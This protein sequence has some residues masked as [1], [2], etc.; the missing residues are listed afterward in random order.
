MSRK[1]EIIENVSTKQDRIATI[2][3]K[4]SDQPILSIAQHIDLEWLYVAF[5]QTRKD[6]VL[7][8]DEQSAEEY[9]SNLRENLESLLDK[10]KSGRYR[11]PAVKRIYIDKGKGG[12]TRP[13]GVPTFEDKVLQRA[14]LMATSPILE[15]KFYDFSYG[16]RKG[17]SAH[18]ALKALRE[19]CMKLGGGWVIDM[20]IRKYFD[21]IDHNLLMDI[22]KQRVC[23]GV[24][25]RVIGKWLKAGVMEAGIISYSDEGTPQG[26][27]ISP[28]LSNIFLHEVLD[29][30]FIKVVQ[31]RLTG[32]SAIIRFADDAVLIFENRIDALRVLKVLPKRFGKYKLTLH[33]EK[34]RLVKFTNPSVNKYD[35]GKPETFSFLGFTLYWGKSRKGDFLL[36]KLKTEKNR[37]A[38]SI[39]KVHDWLK[40]H[41]H[42]KICEHHEKL[43]RMMKGH[44]AY[45][46]MSFNSRAMSRYFHE[47]GRNW[48]KWLK[49]RSQKKRLTWEKFVQI[50]EQYSLPKPRVIHSLWSKP[51]T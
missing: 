2:A 7:G 17:K 45:F 38:R 6:G 16:F 3:R 48:F 51:L 39:R 27:V 21:S 44:Y 29:N 25:T 8:I 34:T 28:F 11:A 37:L 47:C 49:R 24:I 1:D 14:I 43:C 18:Q 40:R 9:C 5:L 12:E 4:Y 41:R 10:L 50:T 36:I 20:D 23:D 35:D 31:P 15:Q 32:R 26:G 13:L 30:W 22:F 46:G 42:Y 33:P 19:I